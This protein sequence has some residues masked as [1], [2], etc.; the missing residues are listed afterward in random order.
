MNGRI[1]LIVNFKG[2]DGCTIKNPGKTSLG[3]ETE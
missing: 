2:S 1:K 3:C